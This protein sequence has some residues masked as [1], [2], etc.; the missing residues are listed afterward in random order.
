MLS[1]LVSLFAM[2]WE[3]DPYFRGFATFK[4]VATQGRYT[5]GSMSLRHVAKTDHSLE[6]GRAISCSNTSGRQIAS[7]VGEIS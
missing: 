6:K 7:C 4:G 1:V 3:W 2:R 5:Q